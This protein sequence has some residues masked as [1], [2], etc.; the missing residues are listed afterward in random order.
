M[1]T[2]AFDADRVAELLRELGERLDR[3]GVSAR[4]FV[5]GGAAMAL[6]YSRDRLTRDIDAVFEPKA[7]VYDEAG[8]MARDHGLPDDWLNDGVKGLLPGPDQGQVHRPFETTGL[9]VE[10]ASPGYMFALKAA[11]ARSERDHDDL[12]T[13]VDILDLRSVD[14]AFEVVESYYE[15]SRL[16]PK[17]QFVVEA[18]V[19]EAIARRSAD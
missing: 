10:V 8:R 4:M 2:E 7:T 3:Q 17:T 5:V 11:A 9:A 18:V 19:E 15:R 6:A 12:V 14:D 13:L 16:A 1:A